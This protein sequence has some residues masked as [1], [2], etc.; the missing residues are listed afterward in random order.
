M[1]EQEKY[2]FWAAAE[3][4]HVGNYYRQYQL[5]T[6]TRGEYEDRMAVLVKQL[7]STPAMRDFWV[8]STG[9]HETDFKNAVEQKLRDG[10]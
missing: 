1:L 3:L 4:Q 8:D 10:P 6:I 5:G 7:E 9:F 2:R